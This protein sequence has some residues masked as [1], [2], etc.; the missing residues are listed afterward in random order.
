LADESGD[1]AQQVIHVERL[2]DGFDRSNAL[3]ARHLTQGRLGGRAQDDRDMG[4]TRV[5]AQELEDGPAGLL[6]AH[7]QVQDDHVGAVVFDEF[8][9]LDPVA[10]ADNLVALAGSEQVVHELDEHDIVVD[11]GDPNSFFNCFEFALSV[12]GHCA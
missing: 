9:A 3:D 1:H 4:G 10:V 8:V 12:D 2:G 7:H 11:D 5:L 6:T